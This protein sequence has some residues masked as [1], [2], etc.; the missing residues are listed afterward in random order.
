V[1]LL[2]ILHITLARLG[3]PDLFKLKI[4]IYLIK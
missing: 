1:R 2:P 3:I 4:K